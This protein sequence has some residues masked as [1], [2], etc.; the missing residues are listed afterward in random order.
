MRL[1]LGI[2][3]YN[4]LLVLLLFYVFFFSGN[5]I[6]MHYLKDV[7]G[8]TEEEGIIELSNYQIAIEYVE[9]DK[10]KKT[11]LYSKPSQGALVYENQMVTLYVSKGYSTEK[12]LNL[13]NQIYTDCQKYIDELIKKYKIEVVI[14]YMKDDNHLD[15]LIYQQIVTDEFIENYDRLELVVVTNPKSV[16]I[17]D[18]IGWHYKDVLKY[19]KENNINISFEYIPILYPKDLVVGQSVSMGQEVLK[20]SNPITIYL[21]KEN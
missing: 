5:D 2:I 8:K 15:G 11:I 20:N 1:Y 21:S 7:S 16:K 4:I 17:P 6:K 13:E 9:S 14:T 12:Y 10:E 3:I 19:S 18:F